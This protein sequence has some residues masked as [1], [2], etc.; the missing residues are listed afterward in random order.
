MIEHGDPIQV[1]YGG[2][3]SLSTIDWRGRAVCTVFLR[4]C[5]LRCS[6][7]Q[8]EAIQAG[9]DYRDTGE[10]AAMIGAS[11]PFI[12]GVVFSGGEP[13]AQKDALLALARAA[14]G[15]G[16]SVGVQTSGLFPGTLEA[17][18]G[19]RLVDKI[20]IDHKTQWESFSCRE[21]GTAVQ[22]RRGYGKNVSRS[23]EV[24]REAFLEGSLPEFEVVVTVFYE[25][26]TS[27]KAISDEIG[28]IP[29]VLQ[30]G[31]HKIPM[32]PEGAANMTEYIARKQTTIGRYTPMTLA[33]IRK[34]AEGLRRDLRIRTREA[35]EIPYT[36]RH[37][38]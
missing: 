28:D 14:K 18:I 22:P 35:G 8:N 31:E 13:A 27:L 21:D 15:M 25:N 16:L 4:G 37:I 26:V 1:N 5:P 33:E 11:A 12:S 36:R 20:A 30:Q 7:C 32:V 23:I 34:I 6:Y 9:E 3:V 2:F 10:I 17:L 24:C 38:L 19:E 29:L